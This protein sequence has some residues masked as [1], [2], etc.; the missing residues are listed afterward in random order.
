MEKQQ[1]MPMNTQKKRRILGPCAIVLAAAN[2]GNWR[3]VRPV[4]DR[5]ACV[6]C[7]ICARYCPCGVIDTEK[8]EK[9]FEIDYTYCK[10]CGI[11]ANECPRQALTMVPEGG[12][13]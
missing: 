4:V 10:G 1:N 6:Q 8:K 9:R 7:G 5:E 2:T 3:L 13:N 12:E 11:C